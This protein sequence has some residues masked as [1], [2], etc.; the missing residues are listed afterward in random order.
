MRLS[1]KACW[2]TA[3]LTA[4]LAL[5]G[6]EHFHFSDPNLL[7]KLSFDSSGAVSME[8]LQH[9]CIA[10]SRDGTYRL[11]RSPIPGMLSS[12]SARL[13]Q[14]VQG[15]MSGEQLQRLKTLLDSSDLRSLSGNHSGIIRQSAETF[16]AEIPIADKRVSDGTLHVRWLNAD[17]KNPF[18]LPLNK[19]VDWLNDFEPVNAKPLADLEF[20]DVCPSVGLQ[21]LQPSVASNVP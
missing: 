3:V 5:Y 21:R 15:T 14:R 10:V 4:S 18:P 11:M 7:A 19:I 13:T 12:D 6:Q 9:V 17:G 2:M 1:V 16:A 20:Q 8:G